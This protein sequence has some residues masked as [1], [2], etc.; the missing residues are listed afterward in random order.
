MLILFTLMIEAMVSSE[1]SVLIRATRRHVPENG[2]L[3]VSLPVTA[4]VVPIS[5]I[6]FALMMES[7]RSSETSACDEHSLP[8]CEVLAEVTP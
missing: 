6:L 8:L 2:I 4:N 3:D 5:L 1:T 7:I